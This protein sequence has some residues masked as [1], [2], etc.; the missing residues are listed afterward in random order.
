ML[1]DSRSHRCIQEAMHCL[2][3]RNAQADALDAPSGQ[4]QQ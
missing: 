4:W 3:F 2:G 1:P